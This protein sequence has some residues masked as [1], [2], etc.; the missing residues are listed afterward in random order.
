M[1]LFKYSRKTVCYS[2]LCILFL[3]WLRS[4]SNTV[5]INRYRNHTG[6][7]FT[8]VFDAYCLFFLKIFRILTEFKFN[9]FLTLLFVILYPRKILSGI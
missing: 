2:M 5:D 8:N 9:M 1:G 3:V 6:N 4:G 7:V